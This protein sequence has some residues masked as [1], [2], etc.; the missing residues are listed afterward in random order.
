MPPEDKYYF[1]CYTVAAILL[2]I[3]DLLTTYYVSPTLETEG[4]TIWLKY[5]WGSW[6]WLALCGILFG[7]MFLEVFFFWL[8]TKSKPFITYPNLKNGSVISLVWAYFTGKS[9]GETITWNKPQFVRIGCAIAYGV[10]F[11]RMIPYLANKTWA[12]FHNILLGIFY[13]NATVK[14]R[15]VAGETIADINLLHNP[16]WD[17]AMGKISL[18]Y[19]SMGYQNNIKIWN[20]GFYTIEGIVLAF[21]VWREYRKVRKAYEA[22]MSSI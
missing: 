19:F 16:I 22:Q 12:C 1:G 20:I 17:T 6:G 21:F 3:A 9:L 4:N 10:G 14:Y 2:N 11:Y 8:H 5:Q 15:T 7:F 13:N 18:W